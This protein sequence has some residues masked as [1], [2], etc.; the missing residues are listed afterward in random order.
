MTHAKPAPPYFET[1]IE[2]RWNDLDAYGH[3]NNAVFVT[4]LEECRVR[5]L[6]QLDDRWMDS[7]VGPVVADLQ[8]GYRQPL[9]WPGGVLAGMRP[10]R[11]GRSSLGISHRIVDQSRPE[12]TAAEADVVLVWIDKSSGQPVPVPDHVRQWVGLLP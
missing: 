9:F 12:E 3:V 10:T 11:L 1:R 4:L 2:L 6:R 7:K 8:L 5:W